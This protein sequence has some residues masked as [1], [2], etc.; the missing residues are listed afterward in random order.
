MSGVVGA[1]QACIYAPCVDR[2]CFLRHL[3]A[4]ADGDVFCLRLPA[5]CWNLLLQAEKLTPKQQKTANAFPRRK[6]AL[7]A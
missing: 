6:F 3:C 1:Q 7:K 5:C 4:H 2:G